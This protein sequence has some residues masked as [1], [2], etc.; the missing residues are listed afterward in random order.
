MFNLVYFQ[1]LMHLFCSFQVVNF[2][3][4]R[5][6]A[7]NTKVRVNNSSHTSSLKSLIFTIEIILKTVNIN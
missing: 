3:T 2:P 4:Y 1:N 7:S 5:K 6:E